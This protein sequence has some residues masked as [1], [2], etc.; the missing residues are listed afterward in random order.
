M[1]AKP[2]TCFNVLVHLLSL[3]YF[4][5]KF[6]FFKA[7]ATGDPK[8]TVT[9]SRNNGAVSDSSRYHTKYDPNTNEHT[10][11]ASNTGYQMAMTLHDKMHIIGYFF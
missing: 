5:G 3:V 9:W 6:A 10:F 8:P 4:T 11:E 1:E 2:K 7:I